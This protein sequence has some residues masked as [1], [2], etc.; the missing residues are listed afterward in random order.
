MN[1]R[2][3]GK[4]FFALSAALLVAEFAVAAFGDMSPG[5]MLFI[6]VIYIEL[7]SKCLLPVI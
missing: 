1:E 4:L 2:L 3:T 5:W 6:F 7:L